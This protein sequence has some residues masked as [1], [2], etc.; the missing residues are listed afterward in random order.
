MLLLE[1]LSVSLILVGVHQGLGR[2]VAGVAVLHADRIIVHLK[3][4]AGLGAEHE[5]EFRI[6]EGLVAPEVGI[7]AEAVAP[8]GGIVDEDL[9]GR[10]GLFPELLVVVLVEQGGSLIEER[11]GFQR[12][13]GAAGGTADFLAGNVIVRDGQIFGHGVQLV[14]D[15]LENILGRGALH[16]VGLLVGERR[17]HQRD[18]AVSPDQLEIEERAEE[19]QFVREQ[20]ELLHHGRVVGVVLIIR[21]VDLVDALQVHVHLGDGAVGP[22]PGGRERIRRRPASIVI[23]V[24]R[25]EGKGEL[26]L[27]RGTGDHGAVAV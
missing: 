6:G 11:T 24:D 3:R 13:R 1:G 15:E 19:A 2:A 16:R 14:D 4:V 22:F 26:G 12:E 23:L 20:F 21:Q 17:R 9:A 5:D 18:V 25:R 7:R 8:E 27:V 10:C